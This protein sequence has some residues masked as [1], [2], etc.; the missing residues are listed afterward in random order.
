MQDGKILREDMIGSP[1]E[2]DLKVWQHSALGRSLLSEDQAALNALGIQPTAA[3]VL[4]E[5]LAGKK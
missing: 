2:E 3:N 4:R 1:L 5:V